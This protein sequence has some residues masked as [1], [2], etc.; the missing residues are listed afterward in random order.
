MIYVT[1]RLGIYVMEMRPS[2]IVF[3]LVWRWQ[4]MNAR[5]HA[6]Y[7]RFYYLY[8]HYVIDTFNRHIILFKKLVQPLKLIFNSS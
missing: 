1:G 2:S 6:K 4:T 8:M 7:N 5:A 3:Q